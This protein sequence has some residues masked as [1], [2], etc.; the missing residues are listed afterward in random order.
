MGD[1]CGFIS[2]KNDNLHLSRDKMNYWLHKECIH[3]NIKNLLSLSLCNGE[4]CEYIN[5]DIHILCSII[6]TFSTLYS[7]NKNICS[8]IIRLYTKKGK[9][10]IKS[11]S[12]SFIILLYD[13]NKNKL[14]IFQDELG[15][16]PLY[17]SLN[18]NHFAFSTS[19]NSLF[20]IPENKKVFSAN[21]INK[22]FSLSPSLKEGETIYDNIFI[23]PK[24]TFISL[25]EDVF[26]LNQ[27][28]K[29]HKNFKKYSLKKYNIQVNCN[30][31]YIADITLSP[32][33]ILN[34]FILE[35]AKRCKKFTNQMLI[36]TLFQNNFSISF[37]NPFF[38]NLDKSELFSILKNEVKADI[39]ISD[40]NHNAFCDEIT[41][42]DLFDYKN[43]KDIERCEIIYLNQRMLFPQISCQLFSFISHFNIKNESVLNS[44]ETINYIISQA[45]YENTEKI[46]KEIFMSDVTFNN[47]YITS[48]KFC[49]ELKNLCKIPTLKMFDIFDRFLLFEK[50][51][52]LNPRLAFYI[53]QINYLLENKNINLEF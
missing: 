29:S 13:F 14:M 41:Y 15:S 32:S 6:G 17:Y 37:D 38:I 45:R 23:L 27:Y 2:F 9:S 1:V 52:S 50:A 44:P 42:L 5:G 20:E 12:G 21:T 16:I 49:I 46:L 36:D 33:Y 39:L 10:F 24:L 22:L 30:P 43:E 31:Y 28:D 51:L 4:Y 35:S 11:L 48:E 26:K 53:L 34:P 3:I 18:E 19:I 7:L 8:S 47:D 25:R 40:Y